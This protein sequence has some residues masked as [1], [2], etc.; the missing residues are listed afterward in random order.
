M[1]DQASTFLI[2][3]S[4]SFLATG[5]TVMLAPKLGGLAN[6]TLSGPQKFHQHSVA[7]IGGVGLFLGYC[8]AA[9][10]MAALGLGHSSPAILLALSAL[11]AFAIGLAE[12]LTKNIGVIFRLLATM[13]SAAIAALL[14]GTLLNRLDVAVLDW[15]LRDAWIAF[16]FTCFA[17]GGIANAINIVDGYNGLSGGVCLIILG[18]LSVVAH[19]VGDSMIVILSVS[20][21]AAL[22]GFMLWNYPNGRIFLGDGGAYALGFLIAE[23]AI[24]LVSRNPSVSPWFPL[25]LVAYPVWE[26]FFSIYRKKILRNQSPGQPDGL[27]LHMMFYKRCVRIGQFSKDPADK[28]RR[29]SATS[30]YLWAL[31]L[32]CAV[33]AMLWW[34]NSPVLAVSAFAFA[35]IYNLTYAKIV[36]F[37]T[38][39]WLVRRGRSA[40][41]T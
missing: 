2:A 8:A 20:L 19:V 30:P 39:R 5:A 22:L 12:D 21:A 14:L 6:D 27:H 31:A 34:N 9:I 4:I 10:S 11:P 33:P 1:I 35:G 29:N 38:P 32:L 3:F 25:M 24:L 16:A 18:A 13:A 28:I 36:R 41:G 26:T 17:V 15:A 7:R 37:K 23:I 40:E